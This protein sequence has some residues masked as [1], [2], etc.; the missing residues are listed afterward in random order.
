MGCMVCVSAGYRF[1]L[2][3]LIGVAILA[4]ESDWLFGLLVVFGL[5]CVAY[6]LLLVCVLSLLVIW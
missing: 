1:G 6:W 4:D 5:C 2:W 3:M